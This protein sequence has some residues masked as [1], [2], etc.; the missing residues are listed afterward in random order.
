MYSQHH[1]QS[2]PFEMRGRSWQPSAQNLAKAPPHSRVQE[3]S[4]KGTSRP[5]VICSLA[6]SP[7]SYNPILLLT[8]PHCIS[9][10][11]TPHQPCYSPLNIWMLQVHF[12]LKNLHIFSL[13]PL[14]GMLFPNIYKVNLTSSS[15]LCLYIIF[16]RRTIPTTTS[17]PPCSIPSSCSTS[18]F[19][20][21]DTYHLPIY[22]VI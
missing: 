20:L 7:K 6:A 3:N 21:C 11:F 10:S 13:F 22:Y 18:S 4:L 5:S 14:P 2:D 8:S 12:H 15:H 16:S 9:S 19:Y 17:C 1:N